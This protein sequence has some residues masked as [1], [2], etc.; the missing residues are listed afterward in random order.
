MKF[1]ITTL[2]LGLAFAQMNLARSTEVSPLVVGGTNVKSSEWIG[3]RTVALLKNGNLQCSATLL[4]SSVA[5]TAAHC[6]GGKGF[7][8]GFAVKATGRESSSVA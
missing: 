4:S 3:Q 1:S 5:L 6:A 2:A 7:Q 8:L